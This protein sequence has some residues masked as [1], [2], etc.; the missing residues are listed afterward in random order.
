MEA[1]ALGLRLQLLLGIPWAGSQLSLARLSRSHAPSW[2]TT[3]QT[4]PCMGI[5]PQFRERNMEQLTFLSEERPA[6]HF[7]LR[8]S[9]QDWMMIVATW[10]LSF[11]DLLKE[12]GPSGWF[13]RTFPASCHP[14]EEGILVPYSEAWSNAGMGSP[15][16]CLTLFISEHSS[17]VDEF[18]SL[19]FLET[20]E[21]QQRY[22]LTE[23]QLQTCE[24]RQPGFRA[25]TLPGWQ[26]NKQCQSAEDVGRS[27]M[28][29][30]TDF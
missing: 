22:Y 7:L 27:T 1:Y 21:A 24:N 14:T 12:H 17:C 11:F 13:G 16:E 18:S 29:T 28:E 8:V 19:H 2:L 20:G 23:R 6:N 10:R 9:E 25:S 3:I 4:F 15:T 26:R 5:L 30:D